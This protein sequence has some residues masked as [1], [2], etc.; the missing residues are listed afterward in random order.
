MA[1]GGSRPTSNRNCELPFGFWVAE[2]MEQAM[3][4]ATHGQTMITIGT[5]VKAAAECRRFL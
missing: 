2:D 5:T 3:R 4:F 1:N